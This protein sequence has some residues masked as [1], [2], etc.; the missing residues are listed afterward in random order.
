MTNTTKAIN[1]MNELLAEG[2]AK[3]VANNT[4][5]KV[6]VEAVNFY[7]KAIEKN[8]GKFRILGTVLITVVGGE[9]EVKVRNYELNTWEWKP[10]SSFLDTTKRFDA[11]SRRRETGND[12]IVTIL[13]SM[14][15]FIGEDGKSSGIQVFFPSTKSKTGV[16]YD[17]FRMLGNK[18]MD[19]L[20]APVNA[21]LQYYSGEFKQANPLNNNSF[22]KSNCANKVYLG[23]VDGVS[24]DLEDAKSTSVFEQASIME[25]AE[26][27]S[28]RPANYCTVKGGFLDTE[29][30]V[31]LNEFDALDKEGGL[32]GF[33][34]V[35]GEERFLRHGEVLDGNI[36]TPAEMVKRT[37]EDKCASCPFYCGQGVKT[38][39]AV[40]KEKLNSDGGYVSPFYRSKFKASGQALLVQVST[41][42]WVLADPYETEDAINIKM[43]NRHVEVVG[44]DDVVAN[45]DVLPLQTE[46]EDVKANEI[47][48]KI[49][50]VF[51]AAF[52]MQ[53][54]S[55]EQAQIVSDII[56]EMEELG[57]NKY[58]TA[59][60]EN[61]LY[62]LEQ[63]SGWEE[64]KE[65]FASIE[66]V[67]DYFFTEPVEG[68]LEIALED[69]ASSVIFKVESNTTPYDLGY[70][71]YSPKDFVGQLDESVEN[72]I[73]D[74]LLVGE[75]VH[76]TGEHELKEL[77]V[78]A[79]N[80]KLTEEVRWTLLN[81]VR[82]S[83]NPKAALEGLTI[84]QVFKDYIAASLAI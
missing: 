67:G 74:I 7:D 53:K 32:Y 20:E 72:I 21:Y 79:L 69:V 82:R 6:T 27:G 12:G 55:D 70:G 75:K 18:G 11:F 42:E 66:G 8:A 17:N 19:L 77:V 71:D 78:A 52:N 37:I 39:S 29:A 4:P 24:A 9:L 47:D 43:A 44:S 28:R 13:M 1:A 25:L 40:N 36:T 83:A 57:M 22:D 80:H 30:I 54:L 64:Q 76:V 58:Q 59:R 62:W 50:F 81:G 46:E 34:S 48:K 61:A 5:V 23:T 51:Y 33:D 60:F 68:S 16:R 3:F 56:D 73:F 14:T 45:I 65:E 35:T 63:A 26:H 31:K 84:A 15:E 10:V 2:V 49:S 38:S 41:G